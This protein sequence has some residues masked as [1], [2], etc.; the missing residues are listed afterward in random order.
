MYHS[1]RHFVEKEWFSKATIKAYT[2]RGKIDPQIWRL[3]DSRITWTMDAIR[4]HFGCSVVM[5]DY[6]WGG[7][8][9]NRGYRDPI[10]LIDKDLLLSELGEVI[11][12]CFSSF[13]SQHCLGQA[14]DSKLT[15]YSAKEVRDDIR[16]YPNAR[17]YRFITCV[18][19]KIS[20]LHIDCRNWEKSQS[21]ILF[22]NP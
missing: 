15:K 20:W 21:G 16:K 14:A 4:D 2:K 5:N 19:R 17:R 18:E 13:G 12:P 22:V 3:V 10:E 1:P 7:K 6:L 11:Q 9:Q 8:N